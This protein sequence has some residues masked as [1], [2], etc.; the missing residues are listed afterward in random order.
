LQNLQHIPADENGRGGWVVTPDGRITNL[1]TRSVFDRWAVHRIEPVVER[2]DR[3]E[4]MLLAARGVSGPPEQLLQQPTEFELQLPEHIPAGRLLNGA[5]PTYRRLLLGQA[6]REDG[7]L[8]TVSA[9]LA[10]LVHTALDGLPA[11]TFH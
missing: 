10:D 7:Q 4:R 6:R 9:D 5:P 1:D 11:C 2:L 3:M 8:E